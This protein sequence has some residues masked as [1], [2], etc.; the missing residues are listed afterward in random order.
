MG[1][2]LTL[3]FVLLSLSACSVD[4][5]DEK[6]RPA[7]VIPQHQLDALERAKNTEALIQEADKKRLEALE[8]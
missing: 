2:W 8:E 5:T 3:M 4:N 7:G 6:T 1:R